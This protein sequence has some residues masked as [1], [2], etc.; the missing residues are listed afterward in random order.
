[1]TGPFFWMHETTGVLRPV[2]EQYLRGDGIEAANVPTMRAYLRQW[3]TGDFRG[4][5][6]EELR[7]GVDGIVDHRTLNAWIEAALDAGVDP[8]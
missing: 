1:M 3:M 7:A 4:P 2:I 6:V 8:L 5:G